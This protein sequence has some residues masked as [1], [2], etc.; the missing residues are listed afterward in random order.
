MPKKRKP[1][2]S[3]WERFYG[4]TRDE[5]V[6]GKSAKEGEVKKRPWDD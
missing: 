6:E 5:Y 4:K 1:G 2:E 3:D